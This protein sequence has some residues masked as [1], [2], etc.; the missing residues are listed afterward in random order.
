MHMYH[1]FVYDEKIMKVSKI[2][3]CIACHFEI[4]KNTRSMCYFF[5]LAKQIM[6][7]IYFEFSFKNKQVENKKREE[8]LKMEKYNKADNLHIEQYV[9][10]LTYSYLKHCSSLIHMYK[11]ATCTRYVLYS[12]VQKQ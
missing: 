7:T 3:P 5:I 1:V 12:S 11:R 6:S 2:F 10:A 8:Y 9:Y 4:F